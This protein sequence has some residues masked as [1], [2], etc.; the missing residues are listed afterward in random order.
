[1]QEDCSP[2]VLVL[3]MP[4]WRYATRTRKGAKEYAR[5]G[6]RVSF[7]APQQVG[8]TAKRAEAGTHVV[9]GVVAHHVRVRPPKT[10]G[11]RRARVAN[12]VMSYLP[13]FC[14]MADAALRRPADVVH[15]TGVPLIPLALLHRVVHRSRLVLDVNERPASVQA[16]GS[17]FAV[18]SK[19]E[20][21]LIRAAAG[22]ALMVTVVAPG[23]AR[24]LETRFGVRESTV[25]RNAPES[26]WR[27][28]WLE[29]P[30]SGPLRLVTV[31]SMFPGRALEMLIRA[32]GIANRRG[33]QVQLSIV[34]VGAPEY[35]QSLED[36]IASEDVGEFVS[37]DGPVDSSA[38]SAAY[39][40]G[41]LGLALYESHDPG[42]DS[43]SNKIIETVASGR[44]V[45]AGDL[46][47]N[48]GFVTQLSVG[49]LTDVDE[50]AIADALQ[51]I[52]ELGFAHLRA[53]A[54]HCHEV[55]QESLVW[56]REFEP[57]VS[58][59]MSLRERK[60]SQSGAK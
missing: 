40:R 41:H 22:H 50:V 8:R 15:V 3:S 48:H 18:A 59:V 42:N 49:W 12:V 58:A 28:P 23:H 36:L 2:S 1:M 17:L 29:P 38:V 32:A 21:T 56:E 45:L 13:A 34:G 43:L 30:A 9:D 4:P 55:S 19:V 16:A 47:E 27:A 52:D 5:H 10:E 11:S 35:M 44:P 7:L 33:V 25:V 24:L 26:S 31:G 60:S 54:V 46:P 39:T 20:P 51:R 14:R 53:L 57:V 37:L 6:L